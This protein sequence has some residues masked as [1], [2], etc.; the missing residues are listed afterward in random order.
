MMKPRHLWHNSDRAQLRPPISRVDVREEA[1]KGSGKATPNDVFDWTQ[2]GRSGA[3]G[4]PNQRFR[5]VQ[6]DIPKTLLANANGVTNGT[7]A[8]TFSPDA[9]CTRAQIV[10]FLYRDRTN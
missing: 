4:D 3:W 6:K 1:T 2:S 8:T 7:G 10:T 5:N 9:T